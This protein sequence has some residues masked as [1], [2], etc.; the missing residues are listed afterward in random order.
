MKIVM[1]CDMYDDGVQYQENLLGKYYSLAGHSVTVLAT[2]IN[3]IRDYLAGKEKYDPASPPRTYWDGPTKIIKLPLRLNFMNRLRYLRGVDA[4]LEAE[5]PEL[6]FVHDVHLNLINAVRYR[7]R[8]PECRIILDYHAD[9]SNSGRN[10]I[11]RLVLHRWS[12]K[13]V[14]D[15]CRSAIDRIYP[16]VPASAD[17]LHEL[18]GVP[19]ESMELLPLGAD[20]DHATAIR[21]ADTGARIRSELGIRPDD[22]VVFTGGKIS[23]TKRTHL[24]IEAFEIL[25]TRAHLVIVGDAAGAAPGYDRL[26]RDK[27]A[28]NP[29]IHFTGWL[30]GS[31]VYRYMD[32]ADVAVFPASQSV[33]WQQ[34][35]SMGLPLI[36]GQV[37]VQDPSYMNL[38]DNIIIIPEA[39]LSARKLAETINQLMVDP[40]ELARRQAG[41]LRTADELLNYHRLV[42]KTLTLPARRAS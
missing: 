24:L 35:L 32:A 39:E 40:A 16:V 36:V 13:V 2:T 37:G 20:T 12:R 7:R 30:S 38:Y 41:A 5:Q 14:L 11:S 15:L 9:A 25:G 10:W 3:S 19:H 6:I 34:A 33:L 18:Y 23:E 29:R 22:F 21:A 31:D 28:A 1:L 17:F 26:L 42:E 8:H 27:A 4:I